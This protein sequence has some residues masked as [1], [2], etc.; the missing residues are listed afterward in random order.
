MNRSQGWESFPSFVI[1]KIEPRPAVNTNAPRYKVVEPNSSASEDENTSF[2]ASEASYDGD[3]RV[4]FPTQPT[5]EEAFMIGDIED[6]L[7]DSYS[8]SDSMSIYFTPVDPAAQPV[9]DDHAAVDSTDGESRES[10][11][12]SDYMSISFRPFHGAARPTSEDVSTIGDVPDESTDSS[13]QCC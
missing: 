13:T 8:C 2:Y 9:A 10:C 7:T 6:E 12:S 1:G 3:D 11:S 4:D 5:A